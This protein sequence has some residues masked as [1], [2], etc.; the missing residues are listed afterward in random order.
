[1]GTEMGD[2]AV[3]RSLPDGVEILASIS[4]VEWKAIVKGDF[5]GELLDNAARMGLLEFRRWL[6]EKLEKWL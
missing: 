4:P 5:R 3:A 6:N 1:M 2:I